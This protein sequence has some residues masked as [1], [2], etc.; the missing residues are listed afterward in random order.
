LAKGLLKKRIKTVSSYATPY[1]LSEEELIKVN[2]IT[3]RIAR[4]SDK[5]NH[6]VIDEV[7]KDIDMLITSCFPNEPLKPEDYKNS[8]ECLI[9]FCKKWFGDSS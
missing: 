9:L 4:V 5:L 2:D 8:R 3:S 1:T 6:E 7:K